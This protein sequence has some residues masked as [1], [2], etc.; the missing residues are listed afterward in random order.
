MQQSKKRRTKKLEVGWLLSWYVGFGAQVFRTEEPKQPKPGGSSSAVTESSW[1]LAARAPFPSASYPHPGVDMLSFLREFRAAPYIILEN[2]MQ[3]LPRPWR[4]REMS[5][6]KRSCGTHWG[7]V[8]EGNIWECKT[9][10]ES[11][12]GKGSLQIT[13]WIRTSTVTK[14]RSNLVLLHPGWMQHPRVW[15]L[16]RMLSS[17]WKG[18]PH[19]LCT[20]KPEG[21]HIGQGSEQAHV[22]QVLLKAGIGLEIFNGSSSSDCSVILWDWTLK[23]GMAHSGH[24]PFPVCSLVGLL[25]LPWEVLPPHQ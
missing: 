1:C 24:F 8:R 2:S 20:E 5:Q 9:W 3:V 12:K 7:N 25:V 19:P 21:G 4:D 17:L 23:H 15:Q 10:G 18:F 11:H 6:T 14:N 13:A 22:V 16:Q